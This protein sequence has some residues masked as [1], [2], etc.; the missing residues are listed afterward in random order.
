MTKPHGLDGDK[1]KHPASRLER[2]QVI[3]HRKTHLWV[4]YESDTAVEQNL[5]LAYAISVHKSQGSEFGRVYFILPKRRG[6]L[7][8]RELFYT[9]LTRAQKHCTLLI[10]EDIGVS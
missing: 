10:Q 2:F 7:L 8:S 1:W 9:A 5:E 3:Y 6:G 4:N